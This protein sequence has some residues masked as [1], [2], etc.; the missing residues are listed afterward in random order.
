M[1]RFFGRFGRF[2]DTLTPRGPVV[3]TAGD[4]SIPIKVSA[5]PRLLGC[6]SVLYPFNFTHVP[7]A[8]VD[9]G[10]TTSLLRGIYSRTGTRL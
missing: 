5:C 3:L 4:F 7:T 1:M 9:N 2:Y 8:S 6:L 10:R